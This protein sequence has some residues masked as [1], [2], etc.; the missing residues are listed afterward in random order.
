MHMRRDHPDQCGPLFLGGRVSAVG[1]DCL[2]GDCAGLRGRE[3]C[4][5]VRDIRRLEESPLRHLADPSLKYV[6]LGDTHLLQYLGVRVPGRH[7]VH[8]NSV[9]PSTGRVRVS[10]TMPAFVA[11]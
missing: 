5:D 3:E 11:S 7:G 9:S 4:D 2:S 6:G 8:A 10:P 1:E